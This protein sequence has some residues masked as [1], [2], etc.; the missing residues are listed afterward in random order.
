MLNVIRNYSIRR[1]LMSIMLITSGVVVV[2]V[3]AVLLSPQLL[4]RP[5]PRHREARMKTDFFMGL[6]VKG[7]EL[8]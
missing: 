1:K 5:V 3:S 6:G 4:S 8:G 2:L 7:L